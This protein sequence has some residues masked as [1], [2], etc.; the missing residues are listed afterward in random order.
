M[1]M[2]CLLTAIALAMMTTTAY[3]QH[4]HAGDVEFGYDDVN[5]PTGFEIEHDEFTSDGFL[6]FESE[7]EELDPFNP[8]DWSSDEPG[9]T[10]ASAEGLLV[11]PGDQIWLNAMDA[12][13]ETTF[14]VGYVNFYN[15]GTDSLE[16][17]GRLGIYDNSTSTADLILSGGSIE[18]GAN[19]QFI[20]LGDI[21]GDVHDHLIV[22][23][24]DDATAPI[25]AYG[26]LFQMQSDY[27]VA[28]G[29]MDLD[30]DPF[31]IIWNYGMSDEDFDDLALPKFGAVEA[32]PEPSTIGVFAFGMAAVMLRRRR[33]AKT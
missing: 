31:W 25:G 29:N 12:A 15:P 10:T 3:A 30:S 11:N 18:S 33:K 21:D 14:G 22:D 26:V 32:V 19:P 27:D 1:K 17:A 7:F 23:L 6:F 2:R 24:L 4:G 28:D 8:G 9:F 5:N 20:G 16:A 13:V